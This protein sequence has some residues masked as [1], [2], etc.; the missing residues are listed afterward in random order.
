MKRYSLKRVN[1][2]VQM[3]PDENGAWRRWEDDESQV[4]SRAWEATL[5]E[6]EQEEDLVDCE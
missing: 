2:T 4:V 5:P 3:V 1:G 6:C